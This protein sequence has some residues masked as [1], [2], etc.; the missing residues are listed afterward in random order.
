MRTPSARPAAA[1]A[2]RA[3]LVGTTLAALA[4]RD[5]SAQPSLERLSIHGYASL[6]A[7]ISDKV[8]VIGI[9]TSGT[10]DYRAAALLFRYAV[11]DKRA[12]V[13]QIANRQFGASPLSS[14]RSD[15][16]LDW[17]F[18]QRKWDSG[19][20]MRAGRVPL[21][22]GI[23]N[24]TR[25]VGTLL[26][27]FR[28]PYNFYT[29]SFT[30]LDGAS[31]NYATEG[32]GFGVD[33]T[34]YG[35]GFD[36]V[37]GLP[38]ATTGTFGALRTRGEQAVGGQLWLTTPIPGVR[39]GAHAMRFRLNDRINSAMPLRPR[40]TL[41][42][43]SVDGNWG[44]LTVRGEATRQNLRGLRYDAW[45][46]QAGVKVHEKLSLWAQNE[47]AD[48]YTR[49][50]VAP[51]MALPVS[52]PYARDRAVSANFTLSPNLVFRLEGHR[53][54]GFFFDRYAAPVAPTQTGLRPTVRPETSYGIASLA[55][56]F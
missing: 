51:T 17:A 43:G 31:V 54:Q 36:Y 16:I 11:D 21:A 37:V 56:S 7:A 47:Q 39:F 42:T 41:V 50:Q 30:S 52:Y 23:Y 53:A 8:P 13:L 10:Q 19:L 6:G 44:R 55:V 15:V 12:V 38:N 2:A 35:G 22:R 25:V 18:Y 34:V 27:F 4:P 32:A 20:S 26:P 28:A 24:E 14:G 48:A 5:A 33:G 29:E 3:L 9:P 1:L 49:L 45:H 46:A 40:A